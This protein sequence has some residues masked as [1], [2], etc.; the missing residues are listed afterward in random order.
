M[1]VDAGSALQHSWKYRGISS[2]SKALRWLEGQEL[3]TGGIR[4][5]NRSANPY[6]EI[7][8][9][10]IPTLIDYGEADLAGRLLRWLLGTQ[11]ADGSYPDSVTG[12]PHIFDSGQVL[13]GLLAGL[14]LDSGARNA[15]VRVAD[16]ICRQVSVDSGFPRQYRGEIPEPILLYVLPPLREAS[17]LLGRPDYEQAVETCLGAYERHPELLRK[18]DLTHFL[19]YEIDALLDLGRQ[20]RVIALLDHLGSLQTGTGAVRGRGNASWTCIPGMAQL[21]LCWYKAGM[22]DPADRALAWM[23]D[24]QLADGGWRGSEGRGADYFR[25]DSVPW[26]AK[27]YLDA[28][29][30]RITAFFRRHARA[31]PD[32]IEASDGRLN[33]VIGLLQGREKILDAGCGKGRFLKAI[34]AVHPGINAVGVD[35]SPELL[36][37]IPTGIERREGWL[38]RLPF[39]T[40]EFDVT[41]SVEAIEQ[42]ANP[43]ACIR[44]LVRVTKPGGHVVIVDKHRGAWGLL[45]CPSWERWPSKASLAATLEEYCS[46]VTVQ[47]IAC[48][49]DSRAGR[50]MVAW[51]GR[52][53]A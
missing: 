16:Y 33:A 45:Q 10:L 5:H 3:P 24:H 49:T 28:H 53:K 26:A 22:E 31:F 8:G 17:R 36:A 43:K 21:S 46:D 40:G 34:R 11:L 15:A 25:H 38:E 14:H 2:P 29:R 12:L 20:D 37:C 42:S 35:P 19:C 30:F 1:L 6:A 39:N 44:E 9:Y 27:Y 47:D 52:K 4:A 51:K 41:F 13:R 50:L 48:G 7:T 23:E 18:E 32:S